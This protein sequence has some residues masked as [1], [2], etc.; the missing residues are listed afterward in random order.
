MRCRGHGRVHMW[1]GCSF[2]ALHL[3]GLILK[4]KIQPLMRI[5]KNGSSIDLTVIYLFIRLRLPLGRFCFW[6][7]TGCGLG[8]SLCG[9]KSKF[10]FFHMEKILRLQMIRLPDSV[11]R[12][13]CSAS[14][15]TFVELDAG[16]NVADSGAVAKIGDGK[17]WPVTR[18]RTGLHLGFLQSLQQINEQAE[19]SN[20]S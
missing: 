16:F 15:G 5:T 17:M 20:N 2:G 4:L 18:K 13:C 14:E 9:Y 11:T 7:W 6:F 1:G 3:C 8:N 10:K 12:S 19:K